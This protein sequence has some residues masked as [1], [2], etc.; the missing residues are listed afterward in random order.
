MRVFKWTP[1]FNPREESPIV[2]VWVRLPKLQIQFFD[3]ETL[4]SIARL[5]GRRFG[6]TSRRLLWFVLVWCGS[7][8]RL[9]CLSRCRLRLAWALGLRCL[10][11][12][13]FMNGCQNTVRLVSIWGML[14]MN[15]MRNLRTEG[16]FGWLRGMIRGLLITLTFGKSWMRRGATG[17]T[18]T[19]KRQ[20]CS[21]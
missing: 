15:A 13:W 21:V 18:Y 6:R 2:P 17:I 10:S 4:F 16:Q 8:L 11:S 14:M 1:T 19:S 7:V 12:R 3:R 5:L 20:T 9:T